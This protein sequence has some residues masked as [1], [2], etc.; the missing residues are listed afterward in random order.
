VRHL[1]KRALAVEII[2]WYGMAAVLGAYALVNLSILPSDSLVCI[3]LNLTGSVCL[4]I[5]SAIKRA[6]PLVA[7]NIVW[8]VIAII[9]LLRIFLI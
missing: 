8:A 6:H 2:G 7:L 4:L 3:L 9:G 5:V 1:A